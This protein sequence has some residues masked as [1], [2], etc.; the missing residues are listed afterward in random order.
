MRRAV[1]ALLSL[2]AL[3]AAADTGERVR[4]AGGTVT[5]MAVRSRA[6]I[7]VL[8]PDSL[9]LESGKTSVR[10]PWKDITT[11]EY[12]M[13]VS[14]RYVEAVLISPVFL[15]AKKRSHYLTVGY[16]DAE[17][18]QQAIVLQ[19]GK[20]AIRPLLVSLEAKSGKRIEFQDE[21][22]RKAGRG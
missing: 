11:L 14:R 15:A 12:G 22:A 6:T 9:V 4:Y 19:V 13:R 2:P 21:E 16:T 20:Q 7:D 18:H 8:R 3:L 5:G 17:G 1:L 10:V